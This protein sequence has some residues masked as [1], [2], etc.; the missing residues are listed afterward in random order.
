MAYKIELTVHHVSYV[1]K[2]CPSLGETC[3]TGCQYCYSYQYHIFDQIGPPVIT[4]S[5][6]KFTFELLSFNIERN[7]DASDRE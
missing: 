2:H 3:K 6:L 4:K 5:L 1:N 7:G